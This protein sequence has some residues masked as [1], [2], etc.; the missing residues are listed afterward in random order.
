MLHCVTA[1]VVVVTAVIVVVLKFSGPPV[2]VV[3]ALSFQV[4]HGYYHCT[5]IPY[6]RLYIPK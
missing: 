2:I 5:S 6:R 3:G 1:V 4:H